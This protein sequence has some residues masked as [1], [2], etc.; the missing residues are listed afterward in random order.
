MQALFL[1]K[2]MPGATCLA[3]VASSK[4]GAIA[5]Q[6]SLEVLQDALKRLGG[7]S[8][9]SWRSQCE[10]YRTDES[11]THVISVISTSYRRNKRVLVQWSGKKIV[12]SHGPLVDLLKNMGLKK[13]RTT[14]T[15]SADEIEIKEFTVRLGKAVNEHEGKLFGSYVAITCEFI[16]HMDEAAKMLEEF[17]SILQGQ[18][19]QFMYK[20]SPVVAPW[21]EFNLGKKFMCKHEA[22]LFACLCQTFLN[23]VAF[24]VDKSANQG[25]I[26]V[27][28][29]L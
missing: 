15:F 16:K 6:Q 5:T 21:S 13:T 27:V 8:K 10:N 23:P 17:L 25:T 7:I 2:N 26:D 19:D 12:E 22:L 20:L 18:M 29:I 9:G 28:E 1:R 11:P 4:E 3:R 14:L 24:D